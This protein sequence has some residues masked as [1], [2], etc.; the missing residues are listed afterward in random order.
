MNRNC[1][2][3]YLLMHSF[4]GVVCTCH[5]AD[6]VP[7]ETAKARFLH[8]IIDHFVAYHIVPVS[9]ETQL[10]AT[11]SPSDRRKRKVTRLT[12]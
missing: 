12:A 11:H 10:A 2:N 8:L 3:E 4:L 5:A 7:L 1:Y 6:I 9:E